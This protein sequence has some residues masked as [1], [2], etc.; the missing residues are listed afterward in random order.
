M[1]IENPESAISVT[2]LVDKYIGTAYDNVVEVGIALPLID[3]VA[4]DLH[5][6][7]RTYYGPRSTFP[8]TRPNGEPI[9]E[10]DLFYNLNDNSMYVYQETDWAV[11]TSTRTQRE[12]IT[13]DPLLHHVEGNT[14]LPC[15]IPYMPNQNALLVF[16]DGLLLK[17][18]LYQETDK[19]TITFP[20]LLLEAGKQVELLSVSAVSTISPHISVQKA[21]YLTEIPYQTQAQLPLG[22]TYVPGNHNLEV[23][24]DGRLRTVGLHYTELN[25]HTVKFLQP[26]V[27]KGTEITFKKGNLLSNV[28]LNVSGISPNY[29]SQV[30]GLTGLGLLSTIQLHWDEAQYLGHTHSEVWRSVDTNQANAVLIMT[31]PSYVFYFADTVEPGTQYTYWVRFTNLL[32]EKGPFSAPLTL[33]SVDSPT[34]LLNLLKGQL[35]ADQLA[36]SLNTRINLID[37]PVTG[38]TDKLAAVDAKAESI[39]DMTLAPDSALALALDSIEA[40]AMDAQASADNLIS[41][42]V[43]PAS[44]IAQKFSGIDTKLVLPEGETSV[45]SALGTLEQSIVGAEGAIASQLSQLGVTYKGTAVSLQELSAV[46][47]GIADTYAAQWSIK[48][49]VAGL[50]GGIGFFNDGVATK[51]LVSADNFEVLQGTQRTAVFAIDGAGNTIINSA[52]IDDAYINNLV[53]EVISTNQLN[54]NDLHIT[55]GSIDMNGGVFHVAADG[56]VTASN[57]T[58]LGGEI[59]LTTDK[60][61]LTNPQTLQKDLEWD[62]QTNTLTLRGKLILQDNT[63]VSSLE[64]IRGADGDTIYIEHQYAAGN[65]GPWHSIPVVGDAWV[66]QRVVTNGAAG[67]WSA[68]IR[69]QGEQGIQGVDGTDHYTWIKYATDANGTGISDD[70]TG[71]S[72]IG[73]AYNKTTA[74]ESTNPADYS[75]GRFLGPQGVAGAA[76]ANGLTTYTWIK[77]ADDANGTGMSDNPT[78]KNYM[79]LAVNKTTQVESTVATDYV[80]SLTKGNTGATGATGAQGI[81]G[82]RGSGRYTIGVARNPVTWSNTDAVTAIGA[83][84]VVDDVVTQYASAA[85]SS[86]LTKIY[87]GSAWVDFALQVHG[88]ALVDGTLVA[89]KIAA[90][91]I[92]G[93]KI[94]AD[95]ITAAHITVSD[96]SN[97]CFNGKGDSL[98]GWQ[99]TVDGGLATNGGMYGYWSGAG[100]TSDWAL[101]FQ[102][103]DTYFGSKFTAKAGDQFHVTADTTPFGGGTSAVYFGIGLRFEDH[104]G[105]PIAWNTVGRG[106]GAAGYIKLNGTV[107]AP[108]NTAKA[109]VFVQVESTGN[110]ILNGVGVGHHATNIEIRRKSAGE[111]IVDGA[112]TAAK[113]AAGTITA[114]QIASNSIYGDRLVA[115]SIYG[116]KIAANTISGSNIAAGTITADRLAANTI[117]GDKIAANQSLSSPNISGGQLSM[118]NWGTYNWSFQ[119]DG[120]M[121]IGGGGGP[122]GAW[123]YGWNT[124]IWNDGTIQTNRLYASGGT[125]D[126]VTINSSC[127]VRG[128]I[129]A[130]KIVGDVVSI[131]SFPTKTIS[132]KS[133]DT[134]IEV[135]S[136]TIAASPLVRTMTISDGYLAISG[137]FN[138]YNVLVSLNETVISGNRND[139]APLAFNGSWT[140]G[141]NTVY[142]LRLVGAAHNG[143]AGFNVTGR[144]GLLCVYKQQGSVIS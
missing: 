99:Q 130:D 140:L 3:D 8:E 126:N 106:A 141:A 27:A 46:T 87:T 96:M 109:M 125:F 108:V 21:V 74:V 38:L 2:G 122:Y 132:S 24:V 73:L 131:K 1:G 51:F 20:G 19:A 95:S 64:D 35:T 139:A 136:I 80:W 59:D 79:G 22:M 56:A 52:I 97:L 124:M 120:H 40:K 114:A 84:P 134:G 75:W 10:G 105:T 144:I 34:A 60:F 23:Y 66:Q 48:T 93:D 61:S 117:T 103:R 127:D 116:D 92:T 118:G 42:Q 13:V 82:I 11:F 137:Y 112:I 4:D 29:P 76:G 44:A 100:V 128:T 102:E 83:N 135:Y 71:K 68:A 142:T 55:G 101:N 57:L 30:T 28:D 143:G 81:Q 45:S 16:M 138:N 33:S 47:A 94:A 18:P 63:V 104:N 91:T 41:L 77:Y 113:I 53:A 12:V 115:G 69:W 121:G 25:N 37:S 36:T 72:Y 98:D 9:H 26:I 58:V 78:G 39:V 107:Q 49:D 86:Q 65:T 70:P 14:V 54:T 90:G 32:E 31:L 111:L 119:K 89:S 133:S 88:N 15:T 123:G 17:Q 62:T 67:V 6:F 129:Y 85:P 43:S 7:V 110:V 50:Q 5:Y